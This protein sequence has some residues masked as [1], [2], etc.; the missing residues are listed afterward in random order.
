M[1]A[2]TQGKGEVTPQ[3]TEPDLFT[4]VEESSV[5]VWGTGTLAAAVLEWDPW[6]KSF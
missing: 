2:K 4:S 1:H 3:K 5:M 6:R